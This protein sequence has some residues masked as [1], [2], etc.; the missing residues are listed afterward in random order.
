MSARRTVA[1]PWLK[2]LCMRGVRVRV[3]PDFR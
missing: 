2:R 1:S 3:K